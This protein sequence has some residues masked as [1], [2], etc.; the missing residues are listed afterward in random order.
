MSHSQMSSG[1]EV[2]PVDVEADRSGLA[3]TE[4]LTDS[5]MIA[6]PGPVGLAA[7]AMT[8]FMLSVFNT[9][10]VSSALAMSVLP[11][12]L[13]Y[14][15][16]VQLLAGMWEFRKGNTFGALAFS[17]FGA[18]WLAYWYYVEHVAAKLPAA[19]AHKA[20]GVFLLGWAIFTAYMTI[21]SLR[22]TGAIAAVFVALTVTFVLLMIGAFATGAAAV[23]MTKAG[24]WAGL[25]TAA[26][27]WYA[28]FA[29]VTNATFKRT[30]LPTW[31]LG[32][33]G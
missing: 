12:A 25:I 18:F 30:M 3:R 11:L 23:D 33:I 4:S 8:T 10:I 28:S 5:V 22:T 6:D 20:T 19:D 32:R 21:A 15:G 13:F 17:S 14:G 26:L 31:P 2:R 16:G 7:F 24:G 27:A 9:N 1:A 29:A